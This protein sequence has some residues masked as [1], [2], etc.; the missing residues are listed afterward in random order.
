MIISIVGPTGVGKS[1]LAIEVALKVHG[2]I[3]NCDAF[4][5]YKYLDIGTAKPSKEERELVPH[6]LFDYV[7]PDYPFSVY[8][9]QVTLRNKIKELEEK[10]VPIILVGGTGLYLKAS[11]YDFSLSKEEEK[12]DM[13]KYLQMDNQTLHQ[14]LEK[15]D[16]EE[17]LK[18]HQNNRKRVLRAIEICLSQGKKKSDIIMSQ[19]HKLLY[20]VTFVGLTK[21]RD[22][23]YDLINKRVDLMFEQGLYL[24]VETLMKKYDHSLRSFQAIGYKEIIQGIENHQ[25]IEEIKELIKKNSRRYAK[26]Q[27]TYFNH[28]LDVNW[29]MDKDEALE[30]ILSK[31]GG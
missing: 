3:V 30:F 25:S 27:Y 18:I 24:E 5:I 31:L 19:E 11:L 15:L 23:L 10:N 16:Y 6:H 14:E 9:Y 2:E 21:P 8:D 22:E 7:E 28:Q 13:S 26:R 29:F 17:S 1:K 12:I 20:D 4:Q